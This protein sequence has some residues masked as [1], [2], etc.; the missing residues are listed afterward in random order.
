MALFGHPLVHRPDTA[1]RRAHHFRPKWQPRSL[2]NIQPL[3][4]PP[5]TADSSIGLNPE[6]RNHS[7]KDPEV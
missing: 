2:V 3:E 4:A 1:F 5:R 6:F 7:R